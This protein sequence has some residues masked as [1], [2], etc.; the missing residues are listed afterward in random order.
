MATLAT[1]PWLFANALAAPV[2]GVVAAVFV[3][4]A[5]AARA[6]KLS[7]VRDLFCAGLFQKF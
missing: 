7:M 4:E 3:V 6:L 2:K 5:C 1:V